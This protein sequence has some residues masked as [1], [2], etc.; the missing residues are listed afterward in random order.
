MNGF[1]TQVKSL[2]PECQDWST[3]PLN[4]RILI[5]K[6]LSTPW[7]RQEFQSPGLKN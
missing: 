7:E 6:V 2:D 1:G 5:K 3:V 4:D